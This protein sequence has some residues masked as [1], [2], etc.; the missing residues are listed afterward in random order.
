MRAV[1]L[2][3]F[4]YRSVVN[5]LRSPPRPPERIDSEPILH[6]NV[7]GPEYYDPPQLSQSELPLC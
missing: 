6:P 2:Q 7:R 4:S 1:A 3:S 5:L